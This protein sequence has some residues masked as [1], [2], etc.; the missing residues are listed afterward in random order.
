MRLEFA[1]PTREFHIG[2]VSVLYYFFFNSLSP[3]IV[4][5]ERCG[6]PGSEPDHHHAQDQGGF[7]QDGQCQEGDRGGGGEG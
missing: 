3:F 2:S 4:L 5:G 6:Q 1:L 7:H